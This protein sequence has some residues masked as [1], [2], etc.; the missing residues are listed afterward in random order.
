MV[1]RPVFRFAPSPNGALHLGHALSALL[2]ARM[3]RVTEGRFLLRVEDIDVARCTPDFEAAIHDDL[4]WLGLAWEE[5][6]RRQSEHF[7]EYDAVL[8]KLIRAGLVYPGF[9]SRSDIRA[10]ISEAGDH[11]KSWPR[12]P[13]GVPHYPPVDRNLSQRE[14]RKRMDGGAPF[15]WRLDVNAA[16]A[17]IGQP[18]TW[19][20]Y[21]DEELTR[22]SPVGASPQNWG[23]IIIARKD[24]PTSYHLAVVLDDADQRITHVV[25]GRDL[26][27][28]TAVQRL[29]QELLGLPEP[30]YFHHRL[31]LGE[32]GRKLSK[33]ARDTGLRE[34]R[35]SGRTPDDIRRL[36]GLEPMRADA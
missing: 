2:N 19:N 9:M 21:A 3:A 26:Y 31:V 33:S 27:H 4:R 25:R 1:S 35:E 30:V 7:A 8:Q 15:A 18:L 32:D 11:G 29:L 22:A 23:D 16:L 36:V 10:H 14:R 12:D 28:A 17:R 20:E 5:P 24:V 6:V 34:L 13:D